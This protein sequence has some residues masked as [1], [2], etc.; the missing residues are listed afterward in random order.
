MRMSDK[1]KRAQDQARGDEWGDDVLDALD[2]MFE[3][4]LDHESLYGWQAIGT[5]PR[6]GTKVLC[7]EAETN[8]LY[9]ATWSAN[10]WKASED[11]LTVYPSQWYKFEE[12]EESK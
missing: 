4:A 3:L 2:V 9:F 8:E 11:G 7:E 10:G 6:D 12:K 5:A 1:I